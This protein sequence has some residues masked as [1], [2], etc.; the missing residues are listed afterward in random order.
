M[1]TKAHVLQAPFVRDDAR[2]RF[3][4]RVRTFV[5]VVWPPWKMLREQ[6][7][8]LFD[9]FHQRIGKIF[10]FEMTAHRLD[11]LLPEDLAATGMNPVIADHGKFLDA[12]CDENQHAIALARL[13]HA[14]FSELLLRCG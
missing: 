8:G 9:R 1:N 7:A 13:R 10:G 3:P 4:D 12:R 2:L 14:H 6:S 11:E 5:A